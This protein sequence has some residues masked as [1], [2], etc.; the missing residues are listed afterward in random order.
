MKLRKRIAFTIIEILTVLAILGTLTAIGVNEYTTSIN[1]TRTITFRENVDAIVDCLNVHFSINHR[2]PDSLE[3]IRGCLNKTPINPFTGEDMLTDGS[4]TYTPLNDGLEYIIVVHQPDIDDHDG[5]GNTD[6]PIIEPPTMLSENIHIIIHPSGAGTAKARPNPADSGVVV[7]LTSKA[8]QCYNFNSWQPISDITINNPLSPDTTF[9]M[10]GDEVSI[11]SKFD[12][13]RYQVTLT[14]PGGEEVL[15]AGEYNCG[16]QVTVQA[17]PLTGHYFVGWYNGNTLVSTSPYYTF[18]IYSDVSLEARSAYYIT[19]YANPTVGGNPTVSPNPAAYKTTVT[20]SANPNICYNFSGWTSPDITITGNTFIMPAKNVSITANYTIK[21]YQ[22]TVNIT[23]T[24]NSPNTP[25]TVSGAGTYNCGSSAT[26]VATPATGFSFTG[27]YEGTTQV[28]TSATYTFTVSGNRTLQARFSAIPYT[29]TLKSNPTGAGS[30]SASPNP[31]AVGQTV[32]L[33]ANPGSCYNFSN[34]TA[35][36][37]VTITNNQFVMPAQNV[38]A[39]ANYTIKTYTIAVNITKTGNSPNTPGTVS[40][41]GT[42]NCG[43]SATLVATPATGFSFTGWYEGTTR[44]STNATYT[45]TVN[46]NRTLQARFSA[47]QYTI[48]L[49]SNPTGAGTSSASPNPAYVGQ[50]VTLSANPGSCYNFSS[51]TVSA[52]SLSG[53][54]LTMP[55]QN[56]TATANYTI[57]TY[58]ITLSVNNSDYGTVSG[59]GTYNCGSSRTISATPKTGYHFVN[60]SDGNTSSSRTFTLTGNI[61]LTANFAPNMYT[62]SLSSGGGGTV[63]G[64]GQYAYGSIAYISATPNSGYRF[65]HWSDGSTSQSRSITVTGNISLTA[66]FVQ[67]VTY[68]TITVNTSGCGSAYGGGTYAAGSSV[69][70]WATPCSGYH[71]DHWSDGNTSSDRW[72]TVTGNETYTAYFAQNVTYYTLETGAV[73]GAYISPS[74]GTHTYAAGTQVTVSGGCNSGYRWIGLNSTNSSCNT[75]NTSCQ[76]TMNSN[77]WVEAI[78]DQISTYASVSCSVS[79]S[80]PS[81]GNK[82][83]ACVNGSC[84]SWG[85][86]SSAQDACSSGSS[87]SFNIYYQAGSCYVFDYPSDAMGGGSPNCPINFGSIT[88]YFKKVNPCYQ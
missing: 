76:I 7:F 40:G 14:S 53:N 83:Q 67:N 33:S 57:K 78:C 86:S 44:V 45:F 31:A 15:G 59:G 71:F 85:T 50:T 69:N 43:S 42:Y 2:Y 58:T 36:A 20:L 17:I 72:V 28:S 80:T 39:T 70:I 22:I 62:V 41:A 11:M 68:Y 65:D 55:A 46:G 47:I 4:I 82:C 51:W 1:T 37:G 87:S 64:G 8:G 54:T 84:G 63:S 61:N 66:Y 75:T 9:T 56:V 81:L 88:V 52:G 79:P 60:W 38:T 13:K 18:R 6:E 49:K 27:W 73:Q 30:P 26:L 74:P 21:Q 35:P 32:T 3:E 23:K 19:L 25:G 34:W 10:I 16:E 77:A 48:T 5:D 24:G 12:I 29:I